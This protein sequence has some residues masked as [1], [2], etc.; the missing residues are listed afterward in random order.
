MYL[1]SIQH[2][3]IYNIDIHIYASYSVY[4]MAS[5]GGGLHKTGVFLPAVQH[6]LSL[7]LHVFVLLLSPVLHSAAQAQN[8]FA[9]VAPAAACRDGSLQLCCCC[10]LGGAVAA[11]GMA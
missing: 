3:H 11:A 1:Y 8:S 10:C 2:T 4:I 9:G 5:C 6:M 7:V